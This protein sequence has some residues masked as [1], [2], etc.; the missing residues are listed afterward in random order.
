MRCPHALPRAMHYRG[1]LFSTLQHLIWQFD[2][3][4]ICGVMVAIW[5]CS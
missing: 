1:L 3:L 2:V 4:V 5:G